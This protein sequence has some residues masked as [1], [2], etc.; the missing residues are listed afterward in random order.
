VPSSIIK[1]N[2]GLKILEQKLQDVV[3]SHQY[4]GCDC[5][6]RPNTTRS[7]ETYPE[8]DALEIPVPDFGT[9]FLCSCQ[10]VP[11]SST[12]HSLMSFPASG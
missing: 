1:I 7:P 6:P 4:K 12:E 10:T 3:S 9:P 2:I 5:Q 8:I 11:R